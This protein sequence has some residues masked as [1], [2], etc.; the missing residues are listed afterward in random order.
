M[1]DKDYF[2]LVKARGK[3]MASPDDPDFD[4]GAMLAVQGD[5]GQIQ[6]EVAR[7]SAP[8]S[9]EGSDI[10]VANLNANN[11][12]VLAGATPTVKKAQQFLVDKGYSAVLLPVSAAFH[13]PLVGHAQQPFSQAIE[14]VTF[15]SPKISVYANATGS[16][17]P[18]DPK[19]IQDTL[20]EHILKPVLF[21]QQIENIYQAGGFCFIEFGPKNILTNL[22]K[23]ILN[24]KP[25]VA[26]ALNANSKK[27][28]DRQLR[29]ALVQLRVIGL[30]LGDLDLPLG[31][32]Q[33]YL[34]SGNNS[35]GEKKTSLKVRL[36][37]NN[38]ISEKTKM[39]MEKALQDTYQITPSTP[40]AGEQGGQGAEE[41]RS[42]GAGE[43]RSRGAREQENFTPAP[44]HPRTPAQNA[45]L[46][47]PG[48]DYQHILD[49]LERGL[50]QFTQDQHETVRV[51]EQYLNNQSEYAKIFFQL[52][53]QQYDLLSKGNATPEQ[54]E[55]PS[56]VTE[57]MR[58]ILDSLGHSMLRFHDHQGETGRI[59]QEYLNN[60]AEY[61]KSFFQLLQQQ[62][63]LFMP[64]TPLWEAGGGQAQS[65]GSAVHQHPGVIPATPTPTPT[66]THPLPP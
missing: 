45:P 4:A 31:T 18:S 24:D 47:N 11:Q 23:N 55:M 8:P 37:G 10:T 5:I 64:H 25:H 66:P 53:Q 29:E 35:E 14:A 56:G 59:H 30:P 15:N 3:A 12:A 16:L 33:S 36:N 22:V 2:A 58:A 57:T 61:F 32:F 21:K 17:Y 9:G 41:Q 50:T 51:H 63:A 27:D 13:T 34:T 48:L 40:P 7:F 39:T 49:N 1:A 43:Q 65:T 19:A 26:V 42:R 46:H 6:A 60:Q 52:M 38:Y 20:A 28:S 44:L 62:Y 54:S